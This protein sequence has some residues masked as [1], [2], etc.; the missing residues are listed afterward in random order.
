MDAV[1]Q[2]KLVLDAHVAEQTVDTRITGD[3]GNG[4]RQ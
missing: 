4:L 1:D 3:D 2:I